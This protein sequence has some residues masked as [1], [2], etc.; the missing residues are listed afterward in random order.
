M[1]IV[2]INTCD[3]SS[4]GNIMLQIAELA[5]EEGMD[6]TTFSPHKRQVSGNRDHHI[7]IGNAFDRKIHRVLCKLTGYNGCFSIITTARLIRRLKKTAP[8]LIHLHNLHNCYINLPMLFG[9]IKRHHVR[10]IWTLHDCWAFTGQCPYFQIA[11]CD[12]WKTGCFK[13]PQYKQYPA[14]FVDRTITMWQLK[15]KWFAGI[16]DM[17]IVTPSE[18]LAG[19]VKQSFLRDYPVKVINN[20]IDLTVFK[21]TSS[22]FREKHGISSGGGYLILGVAFDWGRRKGLDVFIELAKSLDDSYKIALVGIDDETCRQLPENVIAIYRTQNQSE[23]AEVYTA[24]DVFINPTREEVLGMVNIEAL[25]CGTPVI[26]SDAGGCP[27]CVD[28]TCGIVTKCDDIETLKKEIVRVCTEKPY[29][30]YACMQKALSFD[31]NDKF[32]DYV[33]M[34]KQA[35]RSLIE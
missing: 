15:K 5:R 22:D 10:T 30:K 17:T 24:A 12:K 8:D 9:Y 29:S 2:A 11:A 14:S 16:E 21:P 18:W 33:Q 6:V 25:A 26:S 34:Y 19:L 13:C 3:Y 7:Y 23:L 20:G 31:M 32:A 28:H 27:E 4:T 35:I 1:R